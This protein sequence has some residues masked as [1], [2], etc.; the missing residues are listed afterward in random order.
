M[1]QPWGVRRAQGGGVRKARAAHV[2]LDLKAF[3]RHE[4][5]RAQPRDG[6]L[7]RK[8]DR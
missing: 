1:T 2:L 5:K 7:L 3:G 6:P 8:V 4:L